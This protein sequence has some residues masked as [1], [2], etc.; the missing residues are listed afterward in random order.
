MIDPKEILSACME[1]HK[2]GQDSS[3]SMADPFMSG[4]PDL[5]VASSS[6]ASNVIGNV[7]E[8]GNKMLGH[9]SNIKS[10]IDRQLA[11]H[12]DA[13]QRQ[14]SYDFNVDMSDLR[15]TNSVGFPQEMPSNFFA[16]FR[17]GTK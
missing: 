13:Q 14:Q 8:I 5:S 10:T 2:F 3:T 6:N 17:T 9:M 16:P 7:Q 11:A 4:I 15:P 12:Q 1:A